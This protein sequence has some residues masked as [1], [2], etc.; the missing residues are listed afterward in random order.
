MTTKK[1]KISIHNCDKREKE[2]LH[3]TDTNYR[4]CPYCGK[5]LIWKEIK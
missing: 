5:G 3:I 2:S 4:Y 1:R